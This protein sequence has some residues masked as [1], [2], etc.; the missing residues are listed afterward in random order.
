RS[1]ATRSYRASQ[2]G[3]LHR[4]GVFRLIVD[5]QQ[6]F[7]VEDHFFAAAAGQ[8]EQ[9]RQLDG[10]DRASL[11]A[12][13]AEDAP[14]LVDHETFGVFLPVG[15]GAFDADDV[16]A[17]RRASRGAE[18]TGHARHA[19]LLVLVQAMH[20]AVDPR[21]AYLRPHLGEADSHLGAE[22]V[23]RGGGQ[24][25]HE[26]RQIHLAGQAQRRLF[27]PVDIGVVGVHR[28]VTCR[29]SKPTCGRLSVASGAKMPPTIQVTI[30]TAHMPARP[31]TIGARCPYS[32]ST[33]TATRFTRPIGSITFQAK[34]I[35]WSK[36]N[37]G[38][39]Q[40]A[41]MKNKIT[42]STLTISTSTRMIA[43]VQVT[44][45]SA[46]VRPHR[47]QPPKN[48]ITIKNETVTMCRNSAI[49]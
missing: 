42:P 30:A 46:P 39:L 8:V 22:Q 20:A 17:V 4:L 14:Q 19:A 21:I 23:P 2:R 12:H 49:R 7:L 41:I 27:D 25:L 44:L 1:P 33:A 38:Q 37:R 24:T 18:E 45:L 40:R 48:R 26:Q 43:V 5:A 34:L 10:V 31:T 35:N 9:A 15:P 13:A 6:L 11:F 16:D 3:R 28:L 47:C 29:E 32:A 36:R